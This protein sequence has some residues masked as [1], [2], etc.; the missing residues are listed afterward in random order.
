MIKIFNILFLY[1]I[2][3]FINSD[4]IAETEKDCYQYSTKT[5]VGLSAKIKC[6]NNK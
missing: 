2:I 1:T 3:T 6:K 4:A 5:L